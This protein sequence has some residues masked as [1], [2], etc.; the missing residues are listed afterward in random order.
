MNI[1][2]EQ[3]TR[4]NIIK[5]KSF[6][7]QSNEDDYVMVF[8]A[9]HGLLDKDFNYYL[10]TYDTDFTNPALKGLPYDELEMLLDGIKSRKKTLLIDAC[11][12]GEVDEDSSA[13]Q[14]TTIALT[15]SLLKM[16]E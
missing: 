7:Q 12:S 13:T 11:H 5:T 2:D 14:N 8:V 16:L 3:A 6:L 15:K 4:E 9:S 10:A 1:S